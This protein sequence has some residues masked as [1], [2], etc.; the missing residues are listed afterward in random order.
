VNAGLS[1]ANA[2]GQPRLEA[3]QWRAIKCSVES[4]YEGDGRCEPAVRQVHLT[5][6]P[7][8]KAEITQGHSLILQG[9]TG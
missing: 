3:M 2:L 4:F 1:S 5:P 9:Y 6:L 8:V 7:K